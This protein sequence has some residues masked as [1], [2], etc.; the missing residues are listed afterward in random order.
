MRINKATL[1][2]LGILTTTASAEA[3]SPAVFEVDGICYMVT[4][5]GS[6]NVMVC[7]PSVAGREYQFPFSA[8]GVA[9]I[10]ENVTYEGSE[11]QVTAIE[12][13]TFFNEPKLK[14]I[15]LPKS[16]TDIGG[17]NFSGCANLVHLDL[18]KATLSGSLDV[19][20]CPA[21]KTLILPRS[22]EDC[23]QFSFNGD[24][25]LESLWLPSEL[26]ENSR[27]ITCF[28]A[29]KSVDRIYSLSPVPPLFDS[30]VDGSSSEELPEGY[31]YLF[32]NL[33]LWQN[34]PVIYVPEGTVEAYRASPS[35]HCYTDI[36][37]YDT[38]GIETT[39]RDKPAQPLFRAIG[40]RIISDDGSEVD[41]FDISGRRVANHDLPAGVYLV[42][43]NGTSCKVG[44]PR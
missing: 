3:S 6:Q 27:F 32:G 8:E 23:L 28:V 36:R 5:T 35:W 37:E 1:A 33:G 34:Q 26:G 29:I 25:Q 17:G 44:V 30:G 19:Q 43:G 39:L 12:N 42:K 15:T 14:S 31:W 18:S 38:S 7:S 2:F 24:Y 13:L 21:L 41:V 4:E 16:I 22:Q 40:G 11:Y 10:P 20:D 9:E